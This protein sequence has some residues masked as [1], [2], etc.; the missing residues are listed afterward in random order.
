MARKERHVVHNPEGG[1]D[2]KKPH[3][4]RASSHFNTQNEAIA[5]AREICMNQGAEC[6]IHGKKG[7]IRESNSYGNDSCPPK[8]VE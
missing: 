5:S 1:W 3:A 8:D 6:I 2:V 4:D 7:K